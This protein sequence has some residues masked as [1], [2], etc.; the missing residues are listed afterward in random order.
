MIIP[1]RRSLILI[2]AGLFAVTLPFHITAQNDPNNGKKNTRPGEN[3]QKADVSTQKPDGSKYI[4]EF[5][6]PDFLINK[7]RIEHDGSGKGTI[8]FE[9]LADDEAITD[10]LTISEETLER[11]KKGFADSDFLS[12]NEEY[13]DKREFPNLGTSSLTL[14]SGG[15]ERT[16]SLNWTQNK[17]IDGLIKNYRRIGNQYVWMFDINLARQ[18]QPLETPK[19]IDRLDSLLRRGEIADPPQMLPFFDELINDER[20]PLMA[21][22]HTAKLAEQIRKK[23]KIK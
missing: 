10:P 1:V 5:Y 14:A 23:H 12:S 2:F 3:G 11:I 4:Y 15:R 18:N 20:L 13:Q 9:R 21:R 17:H 19:L 16:V 22:N 7:I 6:Q 8:T